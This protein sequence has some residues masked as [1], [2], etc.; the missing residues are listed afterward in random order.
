MQPYTPLTAPAGIAITSG[1]DAFSPLITDIRTG[2]VHG[3]LYNSFNITGL[4]KPQT[5]ASYPNG[6]V[7]LTQTATPG[8]L[9]IDPNR[10]QTRL[11]TRLATEPNGVGLDSAGNVYISDRST[12]FRVGVD[13]TETT[14]ADPTTDEGYQ[15]VQSLAL[16]AAANTYAFFS[17]GGP[18]GTGGLIEISPAGAV[19]SLPS[20]IKSAK[21][22]S[23]DAGGVLYISDGIS[24]SLRA[25]ATD[26]TSLT[27]L[28]GLKAPRGVSGGSAFSG[29]I[30]APGQ[31]GSDPPFYIPSSLSSVE[32]VDG[33]AA[34]VLSPCLPVS[35]FNFGN[36]PVG[37]SLTKTFVVFAVGNFESVGQLSFQPA[38]PEFTVTGGQYALL[39]G[40]AATVAVTF[41]P[42]TAGQRTAELVDASND[43]FSN[44]FPPSFAV[45]GAGVKTAGH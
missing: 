36:V 30:S 40:G 26:G 4:G 33:G 8:I 29:S 38:D 11:A 9:T 39:P 10:V 7:Y 17:T 23:L 37:G 45:T 35:A 14:L 32:I 13:G 22:L 1:G 31:C 2:S 18:N 28:S 44:P 12:I 6:N 21:G 3:L 24:K 19:T 42:K 20:E 25:R 16:D 41:T 34:T 43:F 5:V 27:L 15:G